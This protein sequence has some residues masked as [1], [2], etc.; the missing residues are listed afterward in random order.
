MSKYLNVV[1]MFLLFGW[2]TAGASGL[3]TKS[4]RVGV[5]FDDNVDFS[6]YETYNFSGQKAIKDQSFDNVLELAFSAAMER[7]MLS[8]GYVKDDNPDLLISVTVDV[9]DKTK[10]PRESGNCPSYNDYYSRKPTKYYRY[11]GRPQARLAESRRVFCDYTE[12]AIDVEMVDVNQESTIW[13]GVSLVRIDVKERGFLSNGLVDNDVDGSITIDMIGVKRRS[14]YTYDNTRLSDE[15]VSRGM[16]VKG[17]ILD[18]VA[19]MFESSPLPAYQQNAL[20]V[21]GN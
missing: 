20:V 9:T 4:T 6:K 8:R 12:G 17:Y 13:E 11:T 19:R 15:E 2:M 10:A 5:K 21:E 7:E 16:L 14:T 18:D 1:A 3:D